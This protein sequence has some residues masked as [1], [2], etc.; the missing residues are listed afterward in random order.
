MPAKRDPNK[1]RRAVPDQNNSEPSIVTIEAS[2]EE[3]EVTSKRDD[4]LT[5]M[6]Y[7][8]RW[9]RDTAEIVLR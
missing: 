2:T 5:G 7:T 1:Y 9:V 8:L 4:K 3:T 6:T